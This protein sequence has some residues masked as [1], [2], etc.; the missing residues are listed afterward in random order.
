FNHRQRGFR[1]LPSALDT[2]I[3]IENAYYA[4]NSR[5]RRPSPRVASQAHRARRSAVIR[6]IAR[7]NLVPPRESTR[8]LDGIFG[9]LSAA[10]CEEKCVNVS[11]RNGGE[12]VAQAGTPLGRHKR[13]R[14]AERRRLLLNRPNHA[15][16]A[17]SDVDRHQ[18]A[19]EVDE[20]LPF[21]RPEINPLGTSHRDWIDLRL[22][23]PLIQCV[24]LG[25]VDNLLASHGGSR[26]S[27]GHPVLA[28]VPEIS[29]PSGP[30]A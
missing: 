28:F 26:G 9:G 23:R 4:R 16:V 22:R 6:A 5:P 14:I 7:D 30:S 15:F 21:R 3:G 27:G 1:R 29:K 12:L 2:V 18:L 17:M 11:R 24:L 8:K 13:I 10:I 19:V 25:Q 20:T